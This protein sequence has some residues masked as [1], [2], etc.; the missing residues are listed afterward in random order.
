MLSE[1]SSTNAESFIKFGRGR[2]MDCRL[3]MDTP[4][5]RIT[6]RAA[7]ITAKLRIRGSL[8]SYSPSR[9]WEVATPAPLIFKLETIILS[10]RELN[11]SFLG[12]ESDLLESI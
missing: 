11:L 2:Q 5:Y 1:K 3:P 12:K 4:I 10:L 6:W 8:L 9:I 7:D